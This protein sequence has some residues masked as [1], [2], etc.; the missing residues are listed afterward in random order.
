MG[1]YSERWALCGCW[2]LEEDVNNGARGESER[3]RI[4]MTMEMITPASAI[5]FSQ[6][7]RKVLQWSFHAD[8]LRVRALFGGFSSRTY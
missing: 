3:F 1:G 7:D 8:V 5:P 4:Q 2:R 6:S